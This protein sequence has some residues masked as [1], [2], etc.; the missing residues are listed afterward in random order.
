[1]PKRIENAPVAYT[2][3]VLQLVDSLRT[4]ERSPVGR[5]LAGRSFLAWCATPRLVGTVH[6]GQ[7]D[8]ADARVLLGLY[9][10]ATHP[11]LKP[12]LRRVVDGR[13]FVGVDADAWDRMVSDIRPSLGPLSRTFERQAIVIP[14]GVA[15][16]RIASLLPALGPGDAFR[17]FE[18]VGEAYRWADPRD[19]AR[20][21]TDVDALVETLHGDARMVAEALRWIT[22]HLREADVVRCAAAVSLSPR[23]LQRR[24]SVRRRSFR[25]LV[26]EAR[27][28]AALTLLK[29]TD[30]KVEVVARQVGCSSSSQLGVL[31]RRWGHPPPSSSRGMLTRK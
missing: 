15:G 31:L 2:D 3:E 26:A 11:A 12:P 27:V 4:L 19:G 6:L 1:M 13:H 9:Q 29:T 25:A 17:A 21:Q 10:L 7:R 24:L 22:A 18:N 8:L 5:A 28:N 23:S 16:A 30:L 14:A 20:A